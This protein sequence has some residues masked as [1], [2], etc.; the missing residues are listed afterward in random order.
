MLQIFILHV[1]VES[2][3][4]SIHDETEARYTRW[5]SACERKEWKNWIKQQI[6]SIFKLK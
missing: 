2:N 5:Q 4:K 3:Q 1:F 6:Q